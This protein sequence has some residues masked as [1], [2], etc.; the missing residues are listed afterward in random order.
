MAKTARRQRR[1]TGGVPKTRN[2]P[3]CLCFIQKPENNKTVRGVPLKDTPHVPLRLA[4]LFS[5]KQSNWGL[6]TLFSLN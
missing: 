2:I 3:F 6:K 5:P 4:D 1:D